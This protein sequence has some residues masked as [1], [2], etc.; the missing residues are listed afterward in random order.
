MKVILDKTIGKAIFKV[1]DFMKHIK[2]WAVAFVLICSVIWAVD[3]QPKLQN[4]PVCEITI[5][6]EE[7]LSNIK[8]ISIISPTNIYRKPEESS[9]KMEYVM[10]G[11]KFSVYEING[12]WYKIY[13]KGSWV[14]KN[15]VKVDYKTKDIRLG[16]ILCV[17][18]SFLIFLKI[19]KQWDNYQTSDSTSKIPYSKI[20]KIIFT[21]PKNRL[22]TGLV[23]GGIGGGITGTFIGYYAEPGGNL[24]DEDFLKPISNAFSGCLIGTI[25]MGFIGSIIG[26]TRKVKPVININCNYN[27]YKSHLLNLRKLS[28][29]PFTPRSKLPEF[30]Y[31]PPKVENKEEIQEKED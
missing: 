20:G 18:D 10:V 31:Q 27:L 12:D 30:L 8:S 2:F 4:A 5:V 6:P 23:L 3:I 26:S 25:S 21:S 9:G 15:K 11:R 14:Q 22:L 16:K 19:S 1:E 13:K 24:F 17:A 7:S 28:V 29:F